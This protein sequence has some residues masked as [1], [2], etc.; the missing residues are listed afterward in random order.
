MYESESNTLLS[1]A[2]AL[3]KDLG[4]PQ[5]KVTVFTWCDQTGERIVVAIDQFGLRQNYSIPPFFRGYRVEVQ[6]PLGAEVVVP[7]R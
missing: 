2:K 4:L 5:S 1:A 6:G 3:A 7:R